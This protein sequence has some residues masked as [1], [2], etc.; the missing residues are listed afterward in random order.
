MR[1]SSAIVTLLV[2][3]LC[4]CGIRS[5]SGGGTVTAWGTEV[6]PEVSETEEQGGVAGEAS[7][8]VEID[9]EQLEACEAGIGE[10]CRD[11]ARSLREMGRDVEA[12]GLFEIE[13][14]RDDHISCRELGALLEARGELGAAEAPHR[15]ACDAGDLEAC[16][17]LQQILESLERD[18][19]AQEIRDRIHDLVG[20]D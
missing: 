14:R 17:A 9:T 7:R 8:D 3:T 11:L 19:E 1:A 2:T 13:C 10:G 12:E 6:G 5:S 16:L 4:S 20:E 15:R 18:E